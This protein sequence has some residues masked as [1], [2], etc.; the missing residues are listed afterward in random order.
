MR[1]ITIVLNEPVDKNYIIN[2]KPNDPLK[3]GATAIIRHPKNQTTYQVSVDLTTKA[4]QSFIE[5]SQVQPGLTFDE[6]IE[7]D[8]ALRTSDVLL[9][10]LAKRQIPIND[11]VFYPF[12]SGYRDERDSAAKRRIFRPHAA[13]RKWPEDNYYAHHIEGLVI[14]VDLDSFTV[15]VED[16]L[17]VPQAPKSGNYDPEG[18]KSPDNVPYFPDGVRKDLKP[19]VISQPEGPSF[20]IDGYQIS[21]QKWRFRVGF[22]VREGLTINMVE[23]YDQQRWRSIL[24]RAAIGEMWVP[25]GDASPAHNYKNAFDVGEAGLGLL[26]NSLVLGCDCLGEIHYLDAILNNNQGQAL[27]LK[28]A[29]CI[30]EEDIGMLWKHTE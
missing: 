17:I 5:F 24:Y 14:T 1:I 11:V 12:S 28:N 19:I 20:Q 6:M 2:Y 18:I 22:N 8:Q 29:I 4:I 26:V 21:W 10:A 30:H 27:L 9:A 16:H 3:R 7:A 25:Y 23:Y 13:V 15:D